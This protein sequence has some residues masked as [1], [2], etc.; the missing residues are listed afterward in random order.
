FKLGAGDAT[1]VA[2]PTTA[3]RAHPPKAN[4]FKGQDRR[5]IGTPKGAAARSPAAPSRPAPRPTP[6]PLAAPAP[7]PAAQASGSSDG[8]WETF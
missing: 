8:D 4:A 3:V 6:A 1:H 2:V 7:K 5:S